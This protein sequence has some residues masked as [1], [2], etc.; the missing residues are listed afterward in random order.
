M[1]FLKVLRI[2]VLRVN[3]GHLRIKQIAKFTIQCIRLE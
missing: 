1:N 2:V 3:S